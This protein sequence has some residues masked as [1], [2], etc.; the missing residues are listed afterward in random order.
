MTQL[1]GGKPFILLASDVTLTG[2]AVI[3]ADGWRF[4]I[5]V[6]FRTLVQ[7]L[8]GFRYRFWLKAMAATPTWPQTLTMANLDETLQAQV[9]RKVEA[10]ERFL[11]LHAMALGILQILAL[12][13]PHSVWQHL[14]RWFH[15]RPK[16]G[17]P[18]EQFVQLALQHQ[19]HTNLTEISRLYFWINY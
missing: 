19:W 18:S 9:K 5:E 1:P 6:S 10:F 4:K 12:E 17:Y 14:P 11:N 8:G 3:E 7:L 13:R 15:T 2:P 16:H